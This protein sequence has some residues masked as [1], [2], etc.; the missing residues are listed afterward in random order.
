M[1]NRRLAVIVLLL[2][3]ASTVRAAE[4]APPAPKNPGDTRRVPFVL[5]FADALEKAKAEDRLLFV[6]PIFGGVD[7]EGAADYRCGS[8]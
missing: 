3:I 7:V 8:W 2:A 6:K 1:V 5:P 4:E